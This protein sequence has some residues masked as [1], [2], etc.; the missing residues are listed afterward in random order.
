[1]HAKWLIAASVVAGVVACGA[2]TPPPAPSACGG[3]DALVALSDYASSEVGVVALDGGKSPMLPYANLG[4]D[5]ALAV[6]RGRAFYVARLEGTVFEL[7]PMCGTP[8]G[9]FDVNDPAQKVA[10]NPQDVAAAADG[11]LWIPRYNLGDLA[12]VRDGVTTRIDLSS[13]DADGNPQPSAIRIVDTAV[14]AKAFVALERLDDHDQLR[15]KQ[16][17]QMLRIDVGTR[18]VEATITLAGRNPFNTIVEDQGGLFLAM[19]GNFADAGEADAGVERFDVATSTTRLLVRE[20]DLG[21]SVA[22]VSVRDRC[23]VVILADATPTVNRTS[24]ATFDAQTGAVLAKNVIG[25]SETFDKGLR[26]LAWASS[27]RVLLVGDRARQDAGYPIHAFER[28]DACILH[29]LPDVIF[30]GQKPV[31]VRTVR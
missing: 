31:S 25:P 24:L 26:G 29:A 16:P 18:A 8:R 3:S 5:P 12:I 23:G 15:S 11:A 20:T 1:V 17:S 14:G 2:E 10:A 7:D 28:D 27:G 22:E 13:Y 19:P 4:K 9:Q 6:S 30:V 21:A